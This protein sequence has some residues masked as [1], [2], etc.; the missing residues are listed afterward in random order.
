MNN[1][2]VTFAIAASTAAG[3]V[4]RPFRLPEAV[5]AI[6]ASLI[7]LALGILSPEDS[8]A[9]IMKGADVYLFL[10]GMMLLSELARKKGL[11]DWIAAIATLQAKGS[12][13]RLFVLVYFIGIVV[14][15]LLSNDATAVVLTPAVYA[16]CR[17][18]KVRDPLPYLL[19]CAFIANAASFLLPISNPANLVI[20]A[21]GEMPPLSRWLTTLLFP[22]FVAIAITF[23]TLYWTQRRALADET[24]STD[25]TRPELNMSAMLSG[26]GLVVTAF[27]LVGA[28]ALHA[29]LGLPTFFAGIAT[30]V[31][32]LAVARESPFP[33]VKHV[34]WG[35]LPW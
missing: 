14:T 32:V 18:A 21:G 25:V 12:P 20:F 19:I 3:V 15:A 9:A 27:I 35:I 8:W 31:V 4:F 34:S 33:V 26:I 6:A 7:I 24:L 11:F 22:S 16:A 10:V 23:I 29:D 30:T 17:A 13:R 5:W 28:S 1:S 2:I